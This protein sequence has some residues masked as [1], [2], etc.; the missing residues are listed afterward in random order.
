MSILAR[1]SVC[2]LAGALSAAVVA[3]PWLFSDEAMALSREWVNEVI[4]EEALSSRTGA[5]V[6]RLEAKQ[7]TVA[8]LIAGRLTFGETVERFRQLQGCHDDGQDDVL[9]P[10]PAGGTDDRDLCESVLG[11]A[12]AMLRRH[13]CDE[14]EVMGR[15]RRQ[16][17]E[18]LAGSR[19]AQ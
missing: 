11:W 9:G 8:D 5:V 13:P 1:L 19:V 16:M 12:R 15:L 3:A 10:Y 7:E 18:Y 2:V 6:R 17:R 14:A 4:R